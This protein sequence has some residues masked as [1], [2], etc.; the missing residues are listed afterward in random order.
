[1]LFKFKNNFWFATQINNWFFLIL[2]KGRNFI[3]KW[4]NEFE[5]EDLRT[6]NKVVRNQQGCMISSSNLH[7][8]FHLGPSSILA[9]MWKL[10]ESVKTANWW[11][12]SS[13]QNNSFILSFEDW[14]EGNKE[15][16][17]VG[18]KT[19]GKRTSSEAKLPITQKL[20]Y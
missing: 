2:E 9:S 12:A 4:L 16:K 5:I 3:L 13:N 8:L 11:W 10:I 18:L 7:L 19:K 17:T 6:V 20:K 1:M 14:D 15:K